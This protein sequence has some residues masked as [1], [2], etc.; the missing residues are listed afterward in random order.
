MSRI[1][2]NPIPYWATAGKT[3]EVLDE[4]FGDFH[5]IGFTAVKADVPEDMTADEYRAWIGRYGLSP[6]LSLFNSPFDDTVKVGDEV[7]KAK[8]FAA[9]QVA[10]GLDRTMVSSMSVP[11]RI[12]QPAVGAAFDE[13]RLS[14]AIDMCGAVCRALAAEGLRPLHHSHVG[15]V[16]ET[17]HEITRLLDDLG[18]DVIGFG[19]DTGHLRWAGIDPAPFIR[20]YADRLGGIHIKD[21][22]PDYLAGGADGEEAQED[23]GDAQGSEGTGSG[24]AGGSYRE[25]TASKRL[26]AEP[27]LG[28]VDFDAVL[29]AIP[30]SY[31]GDFMIEV[32]EPSV[33]SKLE[34]H[35]MSFEWARRAL[36]GRIEE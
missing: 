15:G 29:E 11:A 28:V 10:L 4:A 36:A 35:R 14:Q 3:R 30:A 13:G 8:R 31:D 33:D 17:E 21:V 25:K 20:R 1:A 7:E 6:S 9:T 32:D 18:P 16:F 19:P 2:A 12:E 26:W 22:F 34:S 27:G 5:A 24:K 23:S